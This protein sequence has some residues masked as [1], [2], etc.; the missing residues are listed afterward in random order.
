MT[1]SYSS[2]YKDSTWK[3]ADRSTGKKINGDEADS[4][5]E[6]PSKRKS[7]KDKTKK[8]TSYSKAG[9]TRETEIDKKD[10]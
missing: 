9:T 8:A 3:K 10:H 5:K 7:S 4:L 6:K 1:I 2:F